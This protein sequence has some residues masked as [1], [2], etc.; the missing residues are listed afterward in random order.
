[1]SANIRIVLQARFGSSRLPGK[2]LLPVGHMPMVILAARRAMRN[3]AAVVVATSKHPSDDMIVQVCSAASVPVVRGS[4]ENVYERFIDATADLDDHATVVR[5]TA[6]NVF[7][8]ADFI[9]EIVDQLYD[10]KASYLAPRW[11]EGGLPY[12]VAAEAFRLQALRRARPES[13]DDAEHV[14]RALRRAAG[15]PGFANDC[16]LSHLRATVDTPDDYSSVSQVLNGV[17]DAVGIGWREL[18]KRLAGVPV[19]RVPWRSRAGGFQSQMTLGGAQFGMPYGIANETGVPTQDEIARII[20][21]A[22]DHGVTHVDTAQ[23]YGE[24]ELRIGAALQG[25]WRSRVHVVT[26][27][28]PI[29]ADEVTACR[30]VVERSVVRSLTA[31]GGEC[32]DTLLL[33]RAETR[34]VADGAVWN[35]LLE[36]KRRGL[37]RRLGIS[38]QDRVEFDR[39]AADPDV[40]TIQLPFNLLDRRWDQPALRRDNLA[41]HARSVFLQGLLIGAPTAKWPRVPGID[42]T[43]ILETLQQLALDLGRLSVADLAVAFV[44]AQPWIDSLVIGVETGQQLQ[45]NFELFAAPPLDDAAAATVRCRPPVLPDQLLN[46]ALWPI[47]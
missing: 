13:A 28:R 7:P 20:H 39:A 38:V 44:R 25:S 24:S 36:L 8:D 17:D 4:L 2:A 43:S 42:A 1:M 40:E 45:A 33:H 3:G 21:T 29:E 5:L 10:R 35:E 19:P 14:T 46:P 41:I 47:Q 26:K 9:Q 27:L 12:G 34:T 22:I 31:L 32:L 30:S 18:C 15:N 23:L 6:D 16:Q 11:P 37:V